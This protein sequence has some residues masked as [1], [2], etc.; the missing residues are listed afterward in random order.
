M[1]SISKSVLLALSALALAACGGG[2]GGGGGASDPPVQMP[3]PDPGATGVSGKI[4]AP[5]GQTPVA[6]V[7]VYHADAG[8]GLGLLAG[9]SLGLQS[10][11]QGCAPPADSN[12][13]WAC[14]DQYGYFVLEFGGLDP[15]P[16]ALEL[17]FAKGK[18][19]GQAS[20]DTLGDYAGVLP[21]SSDPQAGAPRIAVIT[22]TFDQIENVLVRLGMTVNPAQG[23]MLASVTE[24][25]HDHRHHG[26]AHGAAQPRMVS[27]GDEEPDYCDPSEDPPW[28]WPPDM[29]W[30]PPPEWCDDYVHEPPQWLGSETFDLYI[31]SRRYGGGGEDYPDMDE[32]FE[33]DGGQLRLMNYDILYVNCDAPVPE[34]TNW[35]VSI[36]EFVGQGGLLYVTDLSSEWVTESFYGYVAPD[37][38]SEGGVDTGARVQVAN[39]ALRNWM[40]T[41]ACRN[42]NA[43]VDSNGRFT[44]TGYGDDVLAPH[45][46]DVV[47]LVTDRGGSRV[48]TLR[49]P[50]GDD[51]GQ[52]FFSTFHT[53]DEFFGATGRTAEERML[54]YLFYAD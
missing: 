13:L 9:R 17:N 20:I 54:E 19:S 44:L 30:P 23:Q 4:T 45:N 34:D 16:D 12:A 15:L 47:P 42:G 32:L 14:T 37:D 50:H 24:P 10:S 43:C 5:N 3:P 35:N 51:S 1:K 26:P 21:F 31:G 2:G 39:T 7:T 38:M 33:M 18:W 41:M 53:A 28:W 49:F 36:Q 52:V 11:Q 8:Q 25:T 29:S 27:M 48:L 22:G 46:A 6:G 40:R